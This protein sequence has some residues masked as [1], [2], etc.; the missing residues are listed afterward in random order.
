MQHAAAKIASEGNGMRLQK[1]LVLLLGG[2]L[3]AST[4]GCAAV[5]AV[6][7]DTRPA[8]RQGRGSADRMVAIAKV[9]ESQ[10]RYQHAESMYRQALKH[11]PNDASIRTQIAE[12]SNKR[13][14]KKFA[15]DSAKTAIASAAADKSSTAVAK[16]ADRVVAAVQP[17]T[18]ASSA[19]NGKSAR[20][21][22]I[23][24]TVVTETAKSGPHLISLESVMP[25]EVG[26]W[27][28]VI[29]AGLSETSV[30]TR[31]QTTSGST[32]STAVSSQPARVTAEQILN[33]VDAPAD[34]AE[35]LLNGLKNG[36]S[37]ETQCLAATLLGDC[38]V[39]DDSV[40]KALRTAEKAAADPH[41]RLAI[42]DSRIQRREQD[43]ST[44]ACLI[45][46]LKHGTVDVQVQA[47]FGLRHFTGTTSEQECVQALVEH[48]KSDTA[49]LR[50]SAA[51]ALGDFKTM[52]SSAVDQLTAMSKTDG[53]ND[54]REAAS[55][56]LNRKL[57]KA[58]ATPEIIVTPRS[59]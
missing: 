24:Q 51:V 26:A 29:T 23:S 46:L 2:L 6:V 3:S 17:P 33:I 15:S 35:L 38:D 54:A 34:H 59:E 20:T 39:N 19:T 43:E 28:P 42:C 16:G 4:V 41:L 22:A 52:D 13:S 48:L 12:L 10:G 11:R 7:T 31:I 53:D 57:N 50:S 40:T 18:P 5:T 55:L 36:D 32:T 27:S 14:G 21:V 37:L 58:P 8:A 44:T 45:D 49:I 30:K 1:P 9:F 56:A 25:P 47:C